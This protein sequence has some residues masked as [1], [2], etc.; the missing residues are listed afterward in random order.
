MIEPKEL[1][2]GNIVRCFNANK[3]YVG[4]IGDRYCGLWLSPELKEGDATYEPLLDLVYPVLLTGDWLTEFGFSLMSD[5]GELK[6]NDRFYVHSQFPGS[7]SLPNFKYSTG[8]IT[9]SY[10]HQLQNLFYCLTNKEL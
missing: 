2:I 3:L 5:G 8:G 9:I 6:G 4:W 1:R 10:V 7:I